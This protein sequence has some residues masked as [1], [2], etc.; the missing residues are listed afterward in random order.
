[1]P[2]L[3]RFAGGSAGGDALHGRPRL[4][5]EAEGSALR[6]RPRPMATIHWRQVPLREAVGRLR[7]LY[8]EPVFVDRRV[9]PDMRVSLDITASSAEQVL[10]AFAAAHEL[11]VARLGKLLYLGPSSSAE[12]LR[13]LATLRSKEITRLPDEVRSSLMGR[14]RLSWPRL[15]EPRRLIVLTAEK[16]GW[17]IVNPE[18]IPH[19]LWAA[20]K[21]P[22]LSAAEEFTVLLIGFDLTFK[23]RLDGRAIQVS[24]LPPV[25]APRDAHVARDGPATIG[26]AARSPV[27]KTK[28]VFTLRVQEK[29]VGAVLREL[30]NRLH[31]NVRI[32][33]DAIQAAGKSLDVHVSFTVTNVDRDELLDALLKPAGLDYR[34]E[35]ERIRVVPLQAN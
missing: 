34:M 26:P 14:E 3:L 28:Q 18:R 1:M 2:N 13:P 11:G 12:R 29:P 16:R 9:D 21:L 15:S 24:P 31:W 22:K 35:G 17:R 20:G 8:D 30:A 7:G 27:G 19:D 10:A 33:E 6:H 4:A 5:L 25:A 23:W 32:D